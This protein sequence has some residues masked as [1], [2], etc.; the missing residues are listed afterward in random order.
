ML[1]LFTPA[2]AGCKEEPAEARLNTCVYSSI[3]KAVGLGPDMAIELYDLKADAGETQ[4]VADKHPEI[5]KRIDDYLR[6]ARSE[7]GH[8]PVKAR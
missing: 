4:N 1:A 5:V 3:W 7:S 8:W 2:E 6:T